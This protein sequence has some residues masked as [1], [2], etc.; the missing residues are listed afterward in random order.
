MEQSQAYQSAKKRVEAK[1]SF[2]THLSVYVAVILLL[3]VINLMSSP[4]TIWFHWPMMGWGIAVIIHAFAVFVFPGRFEV[5]ERMIEKE[6][7]KSHS[8]I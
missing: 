4:G 7:N 3:A 2:Y 8:K 1:M 5:S 6:M